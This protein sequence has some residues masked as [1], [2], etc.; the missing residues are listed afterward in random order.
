MATETLQF[1]KQSVETAQQ[2]LDRAMQDFNQ[3]IQSFRLATDKIVRQAKDYVEKRKF[4][5]E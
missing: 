2:E 1:E 4:W 5:L 3:Q